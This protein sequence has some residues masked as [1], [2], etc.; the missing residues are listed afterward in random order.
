MDDRLYVRLEKIEESIETLRKVERAFLMLEANK[1]VLAA[2]LYLKAEGKNVAEKEAQ[3][4]STNDWIN[5]SKGLAEAESAFNHERRM[6]ELRLK[7]YDAEHLTLKT[8][9]PAIRRQA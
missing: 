1:K 5:F 2:Q 4:F 3:A 8:E 7:A 6:Y 9:T